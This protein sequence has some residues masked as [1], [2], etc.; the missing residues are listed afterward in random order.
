MGCESGWKINAFLSTVPTAKVIGIDIAPVFEASML[1]V[2]ASK[3]LLDLPQ[4]YVSSNRERGRRS[5]QATN[6]Q[7]IPPFLPH[8]FLY[9]FF[10]SIIYIMSMLSALALSQNRKHNGIGIRPIQDGLGLSQSPCGWLGPI[11][12]CRSRGFASRCQDKIF[13]S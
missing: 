7:A 11:H 6:P 8:A 1:L 9:I 10:F 12:L 5:E 3:Q 13:W 4:A 2:V